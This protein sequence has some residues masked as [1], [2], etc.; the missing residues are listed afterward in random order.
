MR[1]VIDGAG[2]FDLGTTATA[3]TIGIIDYSRR[4]TDDFGVTTVVERGFARRMSVKVAVPFDGVDA[5]QQR[6]AGLRATPALWVADDRFASLSVRGFYKEFSIDLAIAP[7]S[8]CTLSVEGLAVG[9]GAAD[10]GGD[11]S[12][13]GQPSTLQMVQPATIGTAQLVASNVPE[14]DAPEWSAAAT[15]PRGVRVIK[16]STH[17]IYESLATIGAGDDPEAASGKWLDVG[18]TNR[19]AMFDRALGSTTTGTGSIVV[20]L[21]VGQVDAVALLDLAASTIRVQATGYDRTQAAGAGTTT[22]LDLPGAAGQVTVTISG[23]GTVSVG[24][25]IA[26]RR[27]ALGITEASPTAGI[28]DFSRKVVDDFGGV[29]IV[30]RAWAKRMT[31]NALIR[32]DAIDTVANRLAAVR[33]QPTLWIGQAG[34]DSLTIYGFFKDFSIEVG[35]SV[36][37]LSL[38]IEGLSTAGKVEPLGALIEWPDIA[39]PVG[40]KPA[41]HADVTGDN[42]SKDTNA[43]GGRPAAPLLAAIDQI[44]PITLNLEKVDAALSGVNRA[45]VDQDAILRQADR[46]RALLAAAQISRLLDQRVTR[47]TLVDAGM[48]TDTD[49]GKIYFYGVDQNDKRVSKVEIG[50]DAATNE[51]ALR[52]SY[53]DVATMI[54]QAQLSPGDAAE[55]GEIVQRLGA[56]EI[57]LTGMAAAIA[58]KADAI[59][60]TQ[61]GGMVQSV[62]ETLDALSGTVA[63]KV[64]YTDFNPVRDRVGTVEQLLQSYGDVSTYQLT[65]RQAELRNTDSAAAGIAGLVSSAD[66]AQRLIVRS[67]EIQQQLTVRM[68][69]GDAA[70]AASRLA[71]AAKVG[72]NEAGLLEE[73][74]TR[75]D[76]A[77]A[78]SKRLDLLTATV[79]EQGTTFGA[80]FVSQDRAI[81]DGDKAQSDKTDLLTAAVTKLGTDTAASFASQ[82]R[83]ISDGLKAQSD[84]TDL[85]TATVTQLGHDTTATFGQQATAISDGDRANAKAITQVSAR[86]G[87]FG[88]VSVQQAFSVIA[89]RTGN[90]EGQYTLAISTDNRLQGFKLAGSASGPATFSF[91]DT[92]LNMGTGRVIYNTGVV[93]QVQG[94]GF[95]RD[96][97]LL[98]WFGPSMAIDACT[99]ANATSY[100]TTSGDEYMGGSLSAGTRTNAVRS[101]MIAA[102][103]D[104]TTGQFESAGRARVVTVSLLFSTSISNT[105]A[106][107]VG[108]VSPAVT[109]ELYRGTSAAGVV[110]STRTIAGSYSCEP[111]RPGEPGS[112]VEQISGSFTFT[113]NSGG[114][115]S[116]YYVRLTNRITN[117][118]PGQQI[119]SL[120]SV[121]Q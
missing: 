10:P 80:R 67:A 114:N 49:S 39:D 41:D 54:T 75:A 64:S 36:S 76:Q 121:E 69:V 60:V 100:K 97:D 50:L 89:D 62:S 73:R 65:L 31:A 119:L 17:R 70:E 15:Y 27:V 63:T 16:A 33:A 61:L 101:T 34:M 91:I 93:M 44:E 43:V 85:L 28:A 12:P 82:T 55:F 81:A 74:S 86:V 5:L 90:L 4:V 37:K 24:T 120:I 98:E 40:T 38:S 35:Q 20:T 23:S 6:L 87:D 71:L 118:T 29:T 113:D 104:V 3:P 58:L 116:S 42:T 83:T 111:G 59:T 53:N 72:A 1:V 102:N 32:T 8:Y 105:G 99:R 52:A 25:L 94:I 106:C 45:N 77:S 56:A 107:P 7:L 57:S 78:Q 48:I 103:A 51:I 46:D 14:T 68:D 117:T 84:K 92:D 13:D 30:Q 79:V 66:S 47:M 108:P 11:P 109:V 21:N 18:P 96:G 110:L 26:G 112:I 88:L 19:W 9:D 95:G 2:S 22:F 115:T